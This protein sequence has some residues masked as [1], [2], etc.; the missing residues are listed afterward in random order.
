MDG[1]G[2]CV[3][4]EPGRAPVSGNVFMPSLCTIVLG[5]CSHPVIQKSLSRREK[6]TKLLRYSIL[7]YGSRP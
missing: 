4:A 2:Y 6:Q 1:H 3:T 5:L 7:D